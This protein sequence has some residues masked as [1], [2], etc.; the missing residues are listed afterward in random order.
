MD[1][2][3]QC[4]LCAEEESDSNK[5]VQCQKCTLSVHVLCYGV[6]NKENF[7]CAPCREEL[8]ASEIECAMC[9]KKG[10]ALKMTTNEKWAHVICALFISGAEFTNDEEMEPIDIS[11]CK[12]NKNK[13]CIFCNATF[14]VLKCKKKGCTKVLHISCGL[15]N[16]TLKEI[17]QKDGS[18]EFVGF[19]EEHAKNDAKGEKRL[20]ADNVKRVLQTKIQKRQQTQAAR[21]NAEWIKEQLE[22]EDGEAS[23]IWVKDPN[24]VM[25]Q[26]S[27]ENERCSNGA[28][29]CNQITAESSNT[30][31]DHR[32]A[33][34]KKNYT[35]KSSEKNA[36]DICDHAT[37][38]AESSNK[39]DEHNIK[40]K[41]NYT[42]QTDE[43]NAGNTCRSATNKTESSNKNDEHSVKNI[44]NY[45]KHTDEIN[46]AELCRS[47]ADEAESSNKNN[48][49]LNC[50]TNKESYTEK[51]GEEYTDDSMSFLTD[52]AEATHQCY[53][54]DM[55]KKVYLRYQKLNSFNNSL[56]MF[57]INFM[58]RP[59]S[60]TN[61]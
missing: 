59:S 25:D 45:T 24:E 36:G 27:D 33:K 38:E 26:M 51:L 32:C 46:A 60:K 39:N 55:I 10:G 48:D 22:N 31:D 23:F 47:A 28:I 16:G 13:I 43:Q 1:N 57:C 3:I 58:Y 6:L 17:A 49:Y 44:E 20:S 15:E 30:N 54:D 41:E 7:I 53:K 29:V 61:N 9:L 11:R 4:S 42:K 50:P 19:C 56:C 37:N 21:C 2:Q 5:I 52:D 40:N 12:F 35:K 18:I 34:V 14:G 8:C